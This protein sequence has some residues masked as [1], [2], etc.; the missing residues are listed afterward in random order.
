MKEKIHSHGRPFRQIEAIL[1][2]CQRF[3]LMSHIHP[4]GDSIASVLLFAHVLD[5]FK[6]PCRIL[7]DDDIPKKFDFLQGVERIERYRD[8][9]GAVEPDAVVVL[10]LSSLDRLGGAQ[11]AI[12]P[13][14]KII[15]IDHH[16]S[17]RALGQV[18]VLD[19]RESS[20]TELVYLFLLY[21][22]VPITPEIA[23]LVYTGIVCDTG[24]FLFPNTTCQSL[25]ICSDMIRMGASPETIANRLYFR[26]SQ[27]TLRALA[28]ALS[29]VE[30]HMNGRVSCMH[31]N[32]DE[33]NHHE[34]LDTEG[35]IDSLLTV[36]GTEV[37][38]FMLKLKSR[39]Y[40]VSFRSK[41][42]VDVNE[43]ARFFGGGGHSRASGCQIE[44]T[45]EEVKDRILRVLKKK[46]Q[47]AAPER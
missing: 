31:L 45:V 20:T 15:Q 40:K 25:K 28:K 26:S 23:T 32:K 22:G 18:S 24:R 27:N 44:G 38:F 12:P 46:L 35:F 10:D 34:K 29:T 1:R 47:P 3:L 16:P 8:R 7:L 42:T 39:L 13:G 43:I 9:D 36:D 14:A 2:E 4:D 37:E 19:E 17:E 6:K 41:E 21:C 33:F 30:F 11:K 5:R